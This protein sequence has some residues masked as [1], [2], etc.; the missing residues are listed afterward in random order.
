MEYF[1]RVDVS[2]M[3]GMTEEEK[4][5]VSEKV[6]QMAQSEVN[7]IIQ[8]S[9]LARKLEQFIK[10]LSVESLS[11]LVSKIEITD[12]YHR[13][14]TYAIESI[15]KKIE[16]QKTLTESYKAL[17]KSIETAVLSNPSK[18][19]KSKG[20]NHIIRA[21]LRIGYSTDGL[22]EEIRETPIDYFIEDT[23]RVA[24]YSEYV[25]QADTKEKERITEYLVKIMDTQMVTGFQAFLYEKV[26]KLASTA[27]LCEIFERIKADI[28]DLCKDKVGNYFMQSFISVYAPEEIYRIIEEHIHTFPANSNIVHVLLM[29]AAAENKVSV[30]ESAMERVFKKDAIMSTLLFHETGGFDSKS[31]KLAVKLL[32]MKTKYQKTLQMQCMGLYERYWLF[33]KIGQEVLIALLDSNLDAAVAKLL[34]STMTKEFIG[35]CKTKGGNNLLNA[36]EKVSDRETRKQ[37]AMAKQGLRNAKK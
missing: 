18:A 13:S 22:K 1:K 2:E 35:I 10:H 6:V 23:T 3:E 30:V 9:S 12:I 8:V 32:K 5:E 19:F 37:I 17:L 29:R 14:T 25:D 4:Q 31:Y 21:M 24:T 11:G 34:T 28:P 16:E 7:K 20:T 27:Q 26:C 15:L 33:N 36:I